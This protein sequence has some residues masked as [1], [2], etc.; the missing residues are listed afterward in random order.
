HGSQF[1]ASRSTREYS[2]HV[3]L[4][5]ESSQQ[6]RTTVARTQGDIRLFR[7]ADLV[8]SVRRRS[9]ASQVRPPQFELLQYIII[10]LSDYY[11]FCK[12]FDLVLALSPSEGLNVDRGRKSDVM[13]PRKTRVVRFHLI[14]Q[15]EYHQIV[16][17]LTI[18][19]E[20]REVGHCLDFHSL[21]LV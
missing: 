2:Q 5:V 9:C 16:S 20:E 21:P 10:R 7:H 4:P 3:S 6:T 17:F 8:S 18:S 11:H 13:Q 12:D 19:S 14:L 15:S 1:D